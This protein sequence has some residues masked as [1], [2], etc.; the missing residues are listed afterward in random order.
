M[1]CCWKE[2]V[3]FLI[4]WKWL[5][6]LP[7]SVRSLMEKWL[8]RAPWFL[9][10]ERDETDKNHPLRAWMSR[11][12]ILP[13]AVLNGIGAGNYLY[14]ISFLKFSS[15]DFNTELTSWTASVMPCSVLSYVA[16]QEMA[17][18]NTK[19]VEIVGVCVWDTAE[20]KMPEA[21]WSPETKKTFMLIN[22]ALGVMSPESRA[23]ALH[24]SNLE[25]FPSFS[26]NSCFGTS[27]SILIVQMSP[28]L[29]NPQKCLH[30]GRQD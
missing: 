16:W 6:V 10:K 3:S 24:N 15:A 11:V 29:M 1:I 20:D 27:S 18:T 12:P 28:E 9:L 21:L 25:V 4:F 13:H 14:I 17:S 26:E 8:E 7:P 22:T 23:T 5:N 19:S 2:S 30:A